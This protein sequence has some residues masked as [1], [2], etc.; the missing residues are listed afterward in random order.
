M[1]IGN[2]FYQLLSTTDGRREYQREKLYLDVQETIYKRMDELGV[3]KYR[4]AHLMGKK[5]SWTKEVLDKGNMTLKTIA[6]ICTVLDIDLVLN[7]EPMEKVEK[8]DEISSEVSDKPDSAMF[9]RDAINPT[10]QTVIGG[11]QN[12]DQEGE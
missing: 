2:D 8:I 6:D 3:S 4:L 9:N 11:S 7:Y 10:V 5:K 12:N 1:K